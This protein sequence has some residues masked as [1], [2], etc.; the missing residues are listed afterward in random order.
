MA[1]KN[2]LIIAG[3]NWVWK[4]ILIGLGSNLA[5]NWGSPEETLQMALTHLQEN[6]VKVCKKS[7]ILSTAPFGKTDQPNFA[8]AVAIVE[9]QMEPENL[10]ALLHE[11]EAKAGRVREERWGPRALDLDLL[12]YHGRVE[13]GPPSLPHP[14]IA[15]RAFVLAPIAEIAP[16]WVHPL[17]G[18]SA[19]VLLAALQGKPEGAILS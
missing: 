9:T 14:G 6:G 18:Q 1:E 11:I 2:P 8:N 17:S 5:N 10:L 16:E 3:T 19:A 13:A 15:E 12:D 7:A 4:M